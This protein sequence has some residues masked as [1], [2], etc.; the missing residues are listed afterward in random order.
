VSSAHADRFNAAARP[1]LTAVHGETLFLHEQ[2]AIKELVGTWRRDMPEG[3][4]NDEGSQG[5][6]GTATVVVTKASMPALPHHDA[7]FERNGERWAIVH[8]EA[9][10][11][12]TWI[13]HL[14]RP[15]RQRSMP[16]RRR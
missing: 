2:G 5:Y 6:E 7:E 1:R 8:A 16:T 10:D 11:Q 13:L 4:A 12:W 3:G 15:D 14:A 9:Q